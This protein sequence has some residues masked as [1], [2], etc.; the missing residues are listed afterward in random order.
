MDQIVE[1]FIAETREK[2]DQVDQERA[3]LASGSLLAE[4]LADMV[5]SVHIIKGASGFLGFPHIERVTR[6]GERLLVRLQDGVL[7]QTAEIGGELAALVGAVRQM[8]KEI[9]N[10]GHDGENDYPDLLAELNRL[11]ST[12]SA[13]SR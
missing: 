7:P 5:R 13:G 1:D 3:G 8:L 12:A 2:L 10:T 11:S 9:E 6:A 4:S